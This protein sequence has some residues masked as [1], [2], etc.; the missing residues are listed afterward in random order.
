MM[1]VASVRVSSVTRPVLAHLAEDGVTPRGQS[2]RC[3]PAPA[4]SHYRI[5]VAQAKI[6]LGRRTVGEGE[7]AAGACGRASCALTVLCCRQRPCRAAAAIVGVG[8]RM[9]GSY[10]K[11]ARR[12]AVGGAA[13]SSSGSPQPTGRHDAGHAS[14]GE[15]RVFERGLRD[16]TSAVSQQAS[17]SL[18]CLWRPGTRCGG[19]SKGGDGTTT[20]WQIVPWWCPPF[21]LDA[22]CTHR[23]PIG[24]AV[25]RR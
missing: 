6:S 4:G 3:L 14:P 7:N 13:C 9:G 23:H 8:A 25:P 20:A 15:G 10:G 18:P 11:T 21:H 17:L 1:F 16:D 24:E 5:D 22:H 19:P 2:T 12:C